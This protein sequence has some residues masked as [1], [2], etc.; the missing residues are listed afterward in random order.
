MTSDSSELSLADAAIFKEVYPLI[1]QIEE[2]LDEGIA[3]SLW[4]N[5]TRKLATR[6][7]PKGELITLLN[8]NYDHQVAYNN[9]RNH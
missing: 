7:A 1:K 4:V 9:R 2:R 6:G 5:L 3:L 8:V